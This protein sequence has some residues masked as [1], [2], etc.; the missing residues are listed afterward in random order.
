[1]PMFSMYDHQKELLMSNHYNGRT[2]WVIHIFFW[3]LAF[4]DWNEG[5]EK[6]WKNA[7]DQVMEQI[8]RCHYFDAYCI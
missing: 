2:N 1:M 8:H 6:G 4:V 3:S 5:S 7:Y